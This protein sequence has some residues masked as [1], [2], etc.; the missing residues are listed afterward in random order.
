[1]NANIVNRNSTDDVN[2]NRPLGV[3]LEETDMTT[4]GYSS[5]L[6]S[7]ANRGD[8]ADVWTSSTQA[9]FDSNGTAYPVTYY[10]GTTPT[11]GGVHADVAIRQIPGASAAM[12]CSLLVG[13]VTGVEGEPEAVSVPAI[14][15]LRNAWPNPAR[16]QVNFTYQLPKESSPKLT[17]FNVL[18]QTIKTFDMGRQ[19][20]GYYSLKWNDV[21]MAQGV[22]FYRLQAGD[23]SSTKKLVIIK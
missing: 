17:V 18:G 4:S 14:F 23:Y 1:L 10:N 6:W 22:Y 15:A 8:A 16:G 2:Q 9:N 20:P 5:E 11:T 7:G 19:K 12:S 3:A 13:V 21:N